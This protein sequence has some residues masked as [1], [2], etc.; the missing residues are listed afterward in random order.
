MTPQP[1]Y[2]RTDWPAL[3]L[4]LFAQVPVVVWLF[5]DDAIP[6]V[7][8]GPFELVRLIVLCGLARAYRKYENPLRA[9][10]TFVVWVATTLMFFIALLVWYSLSTTTG[11]DGIMGAVLWGML[12][13]CGILIVETAVS[14]YFFRGNVRVQ[15]ARLDAMASDATT[16]FT[17]G[18]LIVP[19]ILCVLLLVVALLRGMP[20]LI[21]PSFWTVTWAFLWWLPVIYFA[22]KAIVLAQVY[23][24]RFASTGE[25]VLDADWILFITSSRTVSFDQQLSKERDDIA[26]RRAAM[27]GEPPPDAQQA[28]TRAFFARRAANLSSAR[29]RG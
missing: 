27:R 26:W 7:F 24:A 11:L 22:G 25:R 28:A 13:L 1:K 19:F 5:T 20:G 4:S 3:L 16:W 23:T 29:R 21:P 18:F 15:A 14:L 17:F 10:K 8:L 2:R 12:P 9:A 6:F